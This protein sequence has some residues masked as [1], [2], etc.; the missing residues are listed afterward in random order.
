MLS[1][2]PLCAQESIKSCW[3]HSAEEG[4][5]IY[6]HMVFDQT[7]KAS[8]TFLWKTLEP[9]VFLISLFPPKDPDF[10]VIVCTDLE[11]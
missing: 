10:L 5:G 1:Y 8:G 11:Q 3:R 2:S 4:D 7:T 6:T 9:L